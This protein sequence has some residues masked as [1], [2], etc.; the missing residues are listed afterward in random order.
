MD[1]VGSWQLAGPAA[2]KPSIHLA[3]H[4]FRIKFALSRNTQAS[5]RRIPLPRAM[6]RGSLNLTVAQP[7][8]HQAL[9]P[10]PP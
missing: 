6:R 1:W 7:A 8:E 9:L 5:D 10:L 3:C 4:A 2:T